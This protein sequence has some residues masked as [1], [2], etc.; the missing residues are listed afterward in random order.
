MP[1]LPIGG[2]AG[3]DDDDPLRALTARAR[4]TRRPPSRGLWLVAGIVGAVGA[5]AF[6]LIFLVEPEPGTSRAVAPREHGYGFAAGLV[7]GLV[8]GIAVGMAIQRQRQASA[9][10]SSA[11]TP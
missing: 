3:Q 7:V 10:H 6:V 11:S 9:D 1:V 2:M 5:I 4:E 8:V